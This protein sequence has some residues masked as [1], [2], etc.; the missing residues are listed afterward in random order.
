V[1]NVAAAFKAAV[2][3]EDVAKTVHLSM[4]I[5]QPQSLPIESAEKYHF[6]YHTRYGQKAA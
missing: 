4:Q 5:G 2:M 3:T 1:P 6:R